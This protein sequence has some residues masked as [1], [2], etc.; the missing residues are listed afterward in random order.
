MRPRKVQIPLLEDALRDAC[1]AHGMSFVSL[2]RRARHEVVM[3]YRYRPSHYR[4]IEAKVSLSL[5]T[6]EAIDDALFDLIVRQLI[7]PQ[8]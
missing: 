4:T 5:D 1:A 3:T 6:S 8:S 7:E 2:S